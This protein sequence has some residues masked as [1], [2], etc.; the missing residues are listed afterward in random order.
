MPSLP[1]SPSPSASSLRSYLESALPDSHL[2]DA[3]VDSA[4]QPLLLLQTTH[5]M[6]AFAFS[7][8]DMRAS[9]DAIYG[10]FEHYY[11]A[12]QGQ[13]DKLDLAFV[14]CVRPD[15]PNL[16]LFCSNV[17]T[18]VYF[19]RKFVVPFAQPLGLSLARLP[20]LPL[21]PLHGESLRPT[22]AQTFL[23]QCG[24][25]VVLA[26]SLAVQRERGPE[27]IVEDCT[28]G[29]FGEPR[30]LTPVANVPVVSSGHSAESVRLETVTLQNFRAYRKPQTFAFGSDVTVLYGPNG[31]GKTSFF[32]AVDFAV[33]G[34][35]GRVKHSTEAHFKKT[36]QHLDS[37]LEESAV[38]LTFWCNG[39][40]RK[41]K[42][43]VNDRKHALLDGRPAE[44]KLILGELT[45]GDIPATDRVENFVS[46]FRATHLFSQEQQELTKNFQ[47]DCGLPAEIVARMLAVEDYANAVSKAAKVCGVLQGSIT[48]ANAEI[49]EL[50]AQLADERKELERLGQTAK[51]YSNVGALDTEI[52]TL[53]GK[54]D[55]IGIAIGSEKPSVAIVRGWRA[56]L[57]GRLAE[58]Q[59]R[60]GRLSSLAKEATG[61]PQTRVDLA[62]LQEQLAEK[63]QSL[64]TVG[65][66]Q[67]TAEATLQR[68]EQ[69]LGE[70]NRTLAEVQ[71][72][73]GV[74]EWV[75]AMKPEYARLI[76]QQHTVNNE[77]NRT[78]D[79]LADHRLIEEGVAA[80]LRKHDDLAARAAETLM[81]KRAELTLAQNLSES[82]A[83]WQANRVR[84]TSL[85]ESEQATVESLETLRAESH[86]LAP[87][88][89]A[90]AA[91]EARISRQVAQADKS[92]SEFKNLL[93]QLLGHVSTGICPLCGEDHGS[94]D[95][96]L[97]RIQSQMS[98]DAAS[99]ARA[100]LNAA[101]ERGL[102]LAERT[103]NN[104]QQQQAINTQIAAL[105]KERARLDV[106]IA[107][108]TNSAMRLGIV[109]EASGPIPVEPIQTVRDRIQQD[110]GELNQ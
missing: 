12:Q 105:K 11:A 77:L 83:S 71:T 64:T 90:V 7:N 87:Q 55:A 69:H 100:D 52:E 2:T 67:I 20:F 110:I 58:S 72:R 19:C 73:A 84:L 38:S 31:F 39:A 63:Q 4:Y 92:Q 37:K 14:F 18:D 60:S 94:S 35:I 109:F 9:Y 6:A 24:V 47:E 50:S 45:G 97:H 96:L 3:T 81:A 5:V 79:A 104:A 32:D 44:R 33:T 103:A 93:S 108:F 98:E 74:L 43:T 101:R 34:E 80:D 15:A 82:L 76:E 106:E 42:R 23:Q 88:V 8:G 56:L 29:D 48:T 75:R 54:L 78:S 107:Q 22:S 95:E 86:E 62:N 85:V 65:E 89:A 59:S 16:D 51:A 28:N 25:P 68:T 99:D 61:L 1:N 102:Q 13:W 91:E 41:V 36:A 27:R 57:E 40:L 46:L 70:M 21:T 30:E 53:R 26:R 10:S 17:E 66:K 49:K